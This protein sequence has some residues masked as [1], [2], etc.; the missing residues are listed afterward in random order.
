MLSTRITEGTLAA[1]PDLKHQTHEGGEIR[2]SDHAAQRELNC[3]EGQA[4]P[5]S[6][7]IPGW[8]R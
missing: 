4:R 7:F 6:D 1:N 5:K 3:L 8:F 2:D